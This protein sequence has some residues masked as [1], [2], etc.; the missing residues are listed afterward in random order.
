MSILITYFY[1]L[2]LS[3]NCVQTFEFIGSTISN[4]GVPT[5]WILEH[6][7]G[8]CH[9]SK[10]IQISL[11]DTIISYSESN[12]A[13]HQETS[14][15]KKS[16]AEFEQLPQFELAHTNGWFN[17]IQRGRFSLKEPV[18]DTTLLAKYFID[19]IRKY[20]HPVIDPLFK[21]VKS[22]YLYSYTPGLYIGY[23]INK[24]IFLPTKSIVIV[25]TN[26][27]LFASG[28]DTMNGFII[29]SLELN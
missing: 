21:G 6:V 20:P 3:T 19:G 16:F 10:L 26:H 14:S 17:Y 2:F 5:L 24:A 8:E 11:V 15:F 18:D 28:G 1:F 22:K 9:S 7:S 12:F 29:Y 4:S 27:S 13:K 23:K 25:F